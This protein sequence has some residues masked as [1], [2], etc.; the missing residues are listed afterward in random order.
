MPTKLKVFVTETLTY[1]REAI[2]TLPLVIAPT[3]DAGICALLYKAE[4][5]SESADDMM[6]HLTRYGC[7]VVSRFDGYLES[8]DSYEVEMDDYEIVEEDGNL[9]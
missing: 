3:D 6:H 8:P 5:C 7:S 2:V 1:R 4:H 9:E